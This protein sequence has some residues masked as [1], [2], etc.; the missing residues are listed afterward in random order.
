MNLSP[1]INVVHTSHASVTHHLIPQFLANAAI[2]TSL[3]AAAQFVKPDWLHEVIRLGNLPMGDDPSNG[4][5]L[6]QVFTLPA[7]TKFR[8][9]FSTALPASLKVF[10]AWEPNEERVNMFVGYKFLFVGEK[11]R[12]AEGAMADLVARGGGERAKFN[13]STGRHDWHHLLAKEKQK[14]KTGN[15]KGLVIVAD[16][17]SMKIAIGSQQWDEFLEEARRSVDVILIFPNAF[18]HSHLYSFDAACVTPDTI[19]QAVLH[20][21]VSLISTGPEVHVEDECLSIFL[22]YV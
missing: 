1:G 15:K 6:E 5:S 4:S 9:T 16:N 11:D 2:A 8:P 18:N 10:K 7:E 12:E 19:I 13:V 3:V 22:Y 14:Q 21:D 17:K 20:I